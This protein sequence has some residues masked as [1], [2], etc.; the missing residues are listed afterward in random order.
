MGKPSADNEKGAPFAAPPTRYCAQPQ[1]KDP[2]LISRA[3]FISTGSSA[4]SDHN[5]LWP[6]RRHAPA[7]KTSAPRGAD[8]SGD[9]LLPLVERPPRRLVA[10]PRERLVPARADG[11]VGMDLPRR[12][13]RP[14]SVVVR[15]DQEPPDQE[16]VVA[17]LADVGQAVP[18]RPVL[19]AEN[20]TVTVWVAA[21]ACQTRGG[22]CHDEADAGD[23]RESRPPASAAARAGGHPPL[24]ERVLPDDHRLPRG[25]VDV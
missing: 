12:P 22:L 15:R 2:A 8:D 14:G 24:G 1:L 5:H 4:A 20:G 6:W 3:Y 21:E 13:P 17:Q 19:V 16:E 23:G 7:S 10:A 25:R 18:V 9:L 11:V